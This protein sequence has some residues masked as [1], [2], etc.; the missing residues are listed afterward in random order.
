[1]LIRRPWM[2]AYRLER[3]GTGSMRKRVI[4]IFALVEAGWLVLLAWFL[5]RFVA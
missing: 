3:R 2:T 4:G 1:V 5:F